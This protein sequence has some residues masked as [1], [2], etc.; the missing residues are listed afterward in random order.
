M[1][2]ALRAAIV[3]QIME[4][5]KMSLIST[6][7]ATGEVITH[8]TEW[9]QQQCANAIERCDVAFLQWKKI[10]VRQRCILLSK[11]ASVLIEEKITLAEMIT[12]EM[13][14]PI[15]SAIAEVE[16]C[17]LLCEY[18]GEN[19]EKF[20]APKT[21]KTN[22]RKSTIYYQP[23]GIIYAIMPWNFPLWQ[24]MRFAIPNITAGNVGVLKHAPNCMGLS[25]MIERCF[26]TA[27]YPEYVFKT[28][29]IDVDQSPAVINHAKVRGVTITGSE[30]AG[31]AVASEAGKALK[32]VVLELGGSD[33]YIILEDADLETAAN[34]IVNARL[35]NAGQICI[36]PKRIILVKNI[37][38]K[39]KAL[40]LEKAKTFQMGDPMHPQTNLGPLARE[41]LRARVHQQV[42]ML[43]KAGA[44][45]LMGGTMPESQG[46]FYPVTVL[47]NI[48]VNSEAYHEEIFGPVIALCI[49]NNEEEAIALANNTRFGL[50]AAVFT[51]DR[52]K[53]ENMASLLLDAGTCCVNTVVT[54]DPRLPFGGIHNSGFGRELGEEGM[55]EFLNIKTVNVD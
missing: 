6:N 30:A 37:A 18:Y 2:G 42:S 3:W 44:T 54:S 34:N 8:Y 13:G 47:E 49:V 11:L 28:L 25:L 51:R 9:S 23:L 24:V 19:A 14:K 35:A 39:M 4:I 20:L 53:G 52:E 46:Y 12:R 43:V 31:R 5:K 22:F 10:S 45:L 41:D 32:K 33:P 1:A 48:P 17:V 29:M 21:V 38:E 26:L 27:G 15:S 50:G 16:K 55:R 36:A 40:I 7:P